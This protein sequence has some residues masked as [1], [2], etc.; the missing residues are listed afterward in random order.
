[1]IERCLA[2]AT[3]KKGHDAVLLHVEGL[4]SY[5]DHILIVSAESDRQVAAVAERI[6]TAM[7]AHG[8]RPLGT[9]GI[10]DGGWA[11]LDYNEVVVH[12][13]R[14]DLREFYDLEGLWVDAKREYFPAPDRAHHPTEKD[15]SR[16]HPQTSD[17]P[18][19]KD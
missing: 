8:W 1:M 2:A 16:K 4:C 14:E 13:F 15:E 18:A 7:R 10:G 17:G 3:E 11:L 6:T 12:V 9:E 19:P 5:A